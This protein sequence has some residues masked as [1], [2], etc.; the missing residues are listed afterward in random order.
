MEGTRRCPYCAEEIRAEAVRCPYCRSR[1]G[2][3]DPER[4]HRSHPERRLAGV[5][6]AVSHALAVPVSAVRVA[7]IALTFLHCLG[8]LIYGALWLIIPG[9]PAG[10]S[11]LERGLAR[12]L[13]WASRLGGRPGPPPDDQAPNGADRTARAL[14]VP[15]GPAAC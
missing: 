5:A 1:V 15:G 4:W 7:F 12:A 3:F 14:T 6:A 13:A 2:A 10:P 8:P 11:L 9:A